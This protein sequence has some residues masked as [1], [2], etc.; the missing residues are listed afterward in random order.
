MKKITFEIKRDDILAEFPKLSSEDIRNI[1]EDL[2]INRLYYQR[3]LI[4][5]AE[6]ALCQ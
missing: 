3:L 1:E 2:E 5:F 6:R 4:Q